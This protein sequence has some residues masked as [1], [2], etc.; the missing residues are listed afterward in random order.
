MKSKKKK[1]KTKNRKKNNKNMENEREKENENV[2]QNVMGKN[3]P[4]HTFMRNRKLA[5][6]FLFSLQAG[7]V[8]ERE[9][10][11]EREGEGESKPLS[12]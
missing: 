2:E 1:T 4:Q 12:I 9:R 6:R 7:T 11:S 3:V 8:D 10:E 5:N